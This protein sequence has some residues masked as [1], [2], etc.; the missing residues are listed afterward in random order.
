MNHKL[1]TLTM[2]MGVAALTGCNADKSG[3]VDPAVIQ[4]IVKGMTL[5]EKAAFVIGT[6]RVSE[7]PPDAPEC[8]KK[9]PLICDKFK[10]QADSFGVTGWENLQ[11][12]VATYST[13]GRVPG[14]AG[15]H[16]ELPS[17]QMRP[18][19][20]ADGPAGLRI[21]AQRK[22]DQGEYYCTAFPTETALAATWD[23]ALVEKTTKAMGRR[24]EGARHVHPLGRRQRL[25]CAP[26][27]QG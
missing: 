7:T 11:N 20:Y 22:D 5:E 24:G 26:N 12:F 4:D 19:V 8:I 2:A 1:M 10:E 21:D 17:L 3:A 25:R 23:V 18:F 14:A 6:N 16:Y 15:Q 9:Y 27:R 13:Q